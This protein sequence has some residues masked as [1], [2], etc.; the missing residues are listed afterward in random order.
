MSDKKSPQKRKA[1]LKTVV[2]NFNSKTS[3]HLY[4]YIAYK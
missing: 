2:N 1:K 3:I 4:K